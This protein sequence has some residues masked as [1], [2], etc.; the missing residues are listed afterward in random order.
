MLRY[1]SSFQYKN[2]L[3]N[4]RGD[5]WY[6]GLKLVSR[7]C[8][9]KWSKFGIFRE[10]LRRIPEFRDKS[11]N[12]GVLRTMS[13]VAQLEPNNSIYFKLLIMQDIQCFPSEKEV[14]QL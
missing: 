12:S 10:D 3:R 2:L 4:Q 7:N 5:P 14:N 6:S 8:A 9:L 1:S 11:Q 13:G